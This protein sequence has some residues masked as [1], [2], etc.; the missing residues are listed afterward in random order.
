MDKIV[1]DKHSEGVASALI[2]L[3]MSCQT[4]EEADEIM[5]EMVSI[6][7]LW[8]M[9]E[10]KRALGYHAGYRENGVR[11]R[12]ERLF[13]CEH[14]YFGKFAEMGAPTSEEAFQC[15]LR[16]GITLKELRKLNDKG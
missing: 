4:R 8:T 2:D 10:V 3:A 9:K 6:G 5:R 15:G 13:D 1:I 16:G 7:A 14:P 12:V 11:A